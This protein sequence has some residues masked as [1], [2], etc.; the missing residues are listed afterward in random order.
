[1]QRALDL[2]QNGFSDWR[3]PTIQEMQ[4]AFAHSAA[5]VGVGTGAPDTWS[6]TLTGRQTAPPYKTPTAWA[7]NF[8]SGITSDPPVNSGI[9]FIVVRG[10]S[11]VYFADDGGPS[12]SD[13][14]GWTVVSGQGQE[15]DYRYRAKG[16]GSSQAT[17]S[18][19][20]LTG[21][22]YQV[23]TTW[24]PLST[25]AKNAPYQVFNGATLL[26]T[27]SVNQ[28]KAPSTTIYGTTTIP[29]QTLGN[30]TITSSTL[31]VKLNNNANGNVQA[32][33]VRLVPISPTGVAA[34]VATRDTRAAGVDAA[35]A[36]HYNDDRDSRRDL[37]REFASTRD[38]FRRLGRVRGR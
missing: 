20:G 7:F 31:N 8:N 11:S 1:M 12:Y 16:T 33:M 10:G 29:W 32:D 14:G 13:T 25:N 9:G 15:G 2:S 6:M 5:A 24:V 28:Q 4:T 36:S 35:I 22:A 34:V 27:V 3:M 23:Q 26:G 17:W 30:F 19:T 37:L 38:F 18:F 21:G